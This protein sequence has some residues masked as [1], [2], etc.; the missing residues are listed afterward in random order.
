MTGESY[1]IQRSV[2]M[3]T[4]WAVVICL[5]VLGSAG[6]CFG[7]TQLVSDA[8]DSG[9]TGSYLG[10]NWTGCGYNNGAYSQLVYENSAAG[11]S[12]YW[13]QDCSLYTGYGPF[14]SDQYATAVIV[15]S[16]PSSSPQASVQIRGNA[17][18]ATPEYY[19]A[20]G[21]DAQD[22][23]PDYHYRI[24]SMGPLPSS[25][26]PTSLF[27]SSITPSTNDV[28]TC[29]E[30]G[31]TISMQVNGTTV[32]T[33]ADTSGIANGFPGLYYVDPS[34][35]GPNS[36]DVI[37][38]TFSAGSGPPLTSLVITPGSVSTL[39]GSFVQFTGQAAYSDGTVSNLNNW[40]SS[41]TTVATVDPTGFAYAAAP[42][43]AVIT[44]AAGADSNTANLTVG[45]TN[46]Y[47][48]L[49]HD[50][51]TGSGGGYLGSNW[52]GC[53]FDSGAYSKLVYQNNEAGGSGYWS[54]NCSVYTGYGNF[55]NNQYATATVVAPTP[56][57]TPEAS[58]Q[59]R[60]NATP[61]SPESYIACGWDAQ[62]FPAD[63]HYRIWSLAP[64]GNPTSLYLSKVTPA[65]GDTI[66]CQVLGN[67]VTMNVNG[68][69]ISV[70]SDTSGLSAGYPGLYYI[71]PNG[72][73][74]PI[75]DVIFD[76]FVAGQV[77]NAVLASITVTPNPASVTY[78]SSVQF[79]ATGTYTDGTSAKVSGLTWSSSAPSVASISGTGLA[80]GTGAG[81]AAIAAA[82]GTTTGI[83]TLNVNRAASSTA[84]TSTSP[85]PSSAQ[86]PVT[87]NF[88]V[89]GPGSGP[90]G[91]V[92]VTASTRESCSGT[93]TSSHTGS[94]SITF[95]S[96]GSR[97]LSA[98]YSG[99]SNFNSSTSGTVTQRVNSPSI[100]L[101]PSSISYGTV[102]RGTSSTK[103]VT[104]FNT[105]S[106]ALTNLSWS[107]T[108]T[109]SSEFTVAS[110]T[111]GAPPATLNSGG[112][113]SISVTFRPTA[114]GT[115][116]ASLRLS[117]NASNSPQ[118][119]SLS[120]SGR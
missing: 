29:Q 113:C 48:P 8:F 50:G 77:N 72:D 118:S 12:G 41:N 73:V 23:P 15:S 100:F 117:D 60:G 115:Q 24:W 22:F 96:G 43:N 49:V 92:T 42:G 58:I 91:S 56:S 104:I 14:P 64:G 57:S 17:T 44:G 89:T 74:P 110:S 87:I 112:S 94:C 85:N 79:G 99:D 16:N 7:Q 6:H 84:I 45:Q 32:A 33:V 65:T 11:G 30:L 95:S 13:G 98:R 80:T 21:W 27:L 93:L 20:C 68:T 109:N 47:T 108:G 38:D 26:G 97:T 5:A 51:F 103:S 69:N 46:G 107:I 10:P 120:G 111:C 1:E 28:V 54:Q 106:G 2:E 105:G 39:A 81:T 88:T 3:K 90:T 101:S 25:N 52:T 4:L 66:W 119:V 114:T 83:A 35:T 70:V 61:S 18:P 82:S 40:S 71:D 86:Q 76:N 53:G 63:Y 34:G 55:P 75:T 116:T 102:N 9:S 19:V 59:V 67:V 62:D 31:N 78:G 36:T 37:F